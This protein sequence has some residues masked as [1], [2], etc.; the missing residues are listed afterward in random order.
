MVLTKEQILEGLDDL[1]QQG[2]QVIVTPIEGTYHGHSDQLVSPAHLSA[3]TAKVLTFVEKFLPP[4]NYYFTTMK[5]PEV[6]LER[7]SKDR[8]KTIVKCLE[9]IKDDIEKGVLD[10]NQCHV[11]PAEQRLDSIFKKFHKVARQLRTRHDNRSTID[12]KDEYD[13]QDVLHTLLRLF[14]DDIRPEEWT[15]SYCNVSC[16]MDFLLK[17]EQIVIEV[18]KTRKSMTTKDLN[19]QLIIDIEHYKTH[20]DCK[21]VYCFVYDPEGRLGNPQGIISDLEKTHDGFVKVIINPE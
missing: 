19:E 13:V 10:T 20:P 18:K 21:Q 12:I 11:I 1:I 2:N 15:P 16:R 14:F 7:A 4:D 6:T 8:A 3:W 9:S 17:N 5:R